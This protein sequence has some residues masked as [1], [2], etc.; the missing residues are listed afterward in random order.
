MRE[1]RGLGN[2]AELGSWC[3]LFGLSGSSLNMLMFSISLF[4]NTLEK[5]ED[6][7][8]VIY[9]STLG[10]RKMKHKLDPK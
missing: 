2:K 7:K 9:V 5:K 6:L 4:C 3:I 10:N 8:S 1:L